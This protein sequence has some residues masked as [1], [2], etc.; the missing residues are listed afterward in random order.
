MTNI[1]MGNFYTMP[2][3][4]HDERTLLSTMDNI[5]CEHTNKSVQLAKYWYIVVVTRAISIFYCTV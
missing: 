3:G 2:I 1:C 5:Q 4:R